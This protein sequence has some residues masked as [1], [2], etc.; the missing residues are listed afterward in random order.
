MAA[1]ALPSWWWLFAA[2]NIDVTMLLSASCFG[3]PL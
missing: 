2:T 1:V 3:S